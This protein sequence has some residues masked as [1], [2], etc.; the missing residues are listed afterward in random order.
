M[1]PDQG[2]GIPGWFIAFFVLVLLLGI[3]SL[4]WRISVARKLARDAGLDPNSA[5]A[6]TLLSDDGVDAAYLASTLASRSG[7]RA[8]EPMQPARSVEQRLQE[9][10]ALKDKGLITAQEYEARRREILGSI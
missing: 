9:L 7:S 3:G 4:I 8:S 5:T 1:S 10:Q 6:V 2:F